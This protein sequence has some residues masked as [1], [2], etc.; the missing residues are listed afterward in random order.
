MHSGSDA[1]TAE[2]LC[3]SGRLRQQRQDKRVHKGSYV[4]VRSLKGLEGYSYPRIPGTL[5][6]L[7]QRLGGIATG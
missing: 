2:G 6:L 1:V 5:Q 3:G 4:S 7:L